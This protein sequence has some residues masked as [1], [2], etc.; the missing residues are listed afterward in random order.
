VQDAWIQQQPT[1]F[2]VRRRCQ[3]LAVW[4]RGDDEWLKR[5]LSTDAEADQQVQ[6]KAPTAAGQAHTVAPHQRNREVTVTKPD[7]VDVGDS[8]SLPT[9]AGWRYLAVVRDLYSRAVVGWAMA[10]HMRTAVVNHAL[11]MAIDQRQP[12]V[13][14]RIP[15]DRGSQ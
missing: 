7:T 12:A 2:T 14:L 3:L 13:G 5:P 4:R 15:T 8:T 11:A 9:G 10:D 6:D 1:T